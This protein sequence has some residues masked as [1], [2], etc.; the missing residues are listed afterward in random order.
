M[1]IQAAG[2]DCDDG[3]SR[4][5]RGDA[6]GPH[7]AS[8]ALALLRVAVGLETC[9]A[10]VCNVDSSPGPVGASEVLR[11]LSVAVGLP[12][13]LHCAACASSCGRSS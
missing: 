5:V 7:C 4:F 1:T 10:C 8:D 11:T 2:E 12:V 9:D 13:A 6:C 3:D